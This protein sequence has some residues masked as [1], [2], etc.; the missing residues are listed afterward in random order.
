MEE[1]TLVDG[2]RLQPRPPSKPADP[3]VLRVQKN[4][5]RI[6]SGGKKKPDSSSRVITAHLSQTI[7]TTSKSADNA[8]QTGTSD[9]N[10]STAVT[11][12]AEHA[13][14]DTSRSEPEVSVKHHLHED[15]HLALD[16]LKYKDS[17]SESCYAKYID[18][19]N[20]SGVSDDYLNSTG[21]SQMLN[22]SV[23]SNTRPSDLDSSVDEMLYS[24][25]SLPRS[26][27]RKQSGFKVFT[28]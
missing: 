11:V 20:A 15:E 18:V 5:V 28:L 10:L 2:Q 13:A 19:L 22:T 26:A 16:V 14:Y 24:Y 8:L 3:T 17:T 1:I 23:A 9:T 4:R 12:E 6:I 7:A 21:D 27:E 25:R